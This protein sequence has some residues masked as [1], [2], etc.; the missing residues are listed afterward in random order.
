MNDAT[1]AT[2]RTVFERIRAASAVLLISRGC[3]SFHTPFPLSRH[4]LAQTSSTIR[5][6]ASKAYSG[7]GGHREYLALT[8]IDLLKQCTVVSLKGT[9]PGGQHRNKVETGIRII[10]EPT[11][12]RAEAFE[13]RSQSANKANALKRLRLKLALALRS[14]LEIPI[15][16]GD[17][18]ASRS[19][20]QVSPELAAILPAAKQ[21]QLGP[22]HDDFPKG[23]AELLDVMCKVGWS[24]SSA[25]KLIGCSTSQ[26]VKIIAHENACLALVNAERSKIGAIPLKT[27]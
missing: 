4:V 1:K 12:I 14:D 8:E 15:V 3:N 27:R 24:P 5:A 9:G 25:G 26:V 19:T 16:E 23:L 17:S 20:F 10:H 21:R 6:C 11:D 2:M 22:N 13:E 18:D 7:S